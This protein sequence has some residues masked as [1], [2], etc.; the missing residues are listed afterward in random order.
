MLPLANLRFSLSDVL[1]PPVVCSLLCM[2]DINPTN[3]D[4]IVHDVLQLSG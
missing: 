2:N 4:S 3:I 1:S